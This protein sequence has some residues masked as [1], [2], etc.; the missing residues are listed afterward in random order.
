MSEN[1]FKEAV[2]IVVNGK[3]VPVGKI[4]E[5][6]LLEETDISKIL[7]RRLNKDS[8]HLNYLSMDKCTEHANHL[9]KNMFEYLYEKQIN[10]SWN[11]SAKN[12]I[13]IFVFQRDE[14]PIP[15][16]HVYHDKELNMR[17]CSFIRLDKAEYSPHHDIIPLPGY[18]EQSFIDVMTSIL[19]RKSDGE[20]SGT[21][22]YQA[23]VDT[24]LATFGFAKDIHIDVDEDTGL[25]I[26]PPYQ[27]LFKK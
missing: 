8:G 3:E 6:V 10:P 16:M 7:Y 21:T 5:F 26:M 18:L 27:E 1:L 19:P 15:H 14:G 12:P 4:E 17:K 24:W 2:S 25:W 20:P 9:M 13:Y 23:A 11:K 22:G